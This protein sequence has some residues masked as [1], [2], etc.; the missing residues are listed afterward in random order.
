V[1]RPQ[2]HTIATA[3]QSCVCTEINIYS[4][5]S[6]V[7]WGFAP[8]PTGGAY[9]APPDLLAG[10]GGGGSPG[11]RKEGGE[12]GKEGGEGRGGMEG[13]ERVESPR[14]P[15]SRVGKPISTT[16]VANNIFKIAWNVVY[17]LSKCLNILAICEWYW[18]PAV[19]TPTPR[20][21]R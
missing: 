4:Y 21:H 5:E 10:L 16:F 13:E 8:D 11:K 6:F 15:K 20:H 9:S 12:R 17:W 19:L 14:M 7:G 2:T 3:K 18:G 1:L